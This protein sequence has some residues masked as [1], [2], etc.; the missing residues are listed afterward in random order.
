MKV[1]DASDKEKEAIALKH[2][3]A[4]I[5][6]EYNYYCMLKEVSLEDTEDDL[7]QKRLYKLAKKGNPVAIK[8]LLWERSDHEYEGYEIESV[9]T[10]EDYKKDVHHRR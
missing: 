4:I 8:R 6:E 10:E 5:D 9:L 2:M 1:F 3:F 7:D